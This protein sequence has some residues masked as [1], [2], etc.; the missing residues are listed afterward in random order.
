[1][2][3]TASTSSETSLWA[4]YKATGDT[5]A[6]DR[7][8]MLYQPLV[9]RIAADAS[10]YVLSVG[11]RTTELDDLKSL[12]QEGLIRVMG[13]FDPG[14]GVPFPAYARIRVLGYVKDA[15]RED[16][17]LTRRQRQNVQALLRGQK[18]TERRAREAARIASQRP[19]TGV[20]IETLEA[21]PSDGQLEE[22]VLAQL[23]VGQVLESL[24]PME[25]AVL[26]YRYLKGMS[27][28]AIAALL[29]VTTSRV[30]QIH[31]TALGR[32]KGLQAN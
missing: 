24:G 13:S 20:A 17:Y 7:L 27:L 30:S 25:R 11:A 1:M 16:D 14:R 22:D 5:E 21:L 12:A 23:Q 4:A 19:K 18:L 3:T 15:L 29:Q 9:R 6:R 28:S 26:N 32:L 31:K 2:S 10:S 8:I